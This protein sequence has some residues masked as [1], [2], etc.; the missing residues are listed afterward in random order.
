M[1][2]DSPQDTTFL[3]EICLNVFKK[4]NISQPTC[5]SQLPHL[6]DIYC[7]N[8]L[9]CMYGSYAY[10]TFIKFNISISLSH[11]S[12]LAIGITTQNFGK[13][14]YPNLSIVLQQLRRSYGK[15]DIQFIENENTVRFKAYSYI[16][17]LSRTSECI[18]EKIDSSF[19][20]IFKLFC[21]LF[22]LPLVSYILRPRALTKEKEPQKHSLV[23]TKYITDSTHTDMKSI[24]VSTIEKEGFRKLNV[25]SKEGTTFI[26]FAV[27]LE[28]NIELLRSFP[29][30]F[31]LTSC[32]IQVKIFFTLS[33]K[34]TF[35]F[36][37]DDF[38]E[39]V[40]YC[41]QKNYEL[42]DEKYGFDMKQRCLYYGM[43]ILYPLY[44]K[45]S[46]PTLAKYLLRNS[47]RG[48]SYFAHNLLK[49]L[50]ELKILDCPLED[51]RTFEKDAL[52]LNRK[53]SCCVNIEV[54]MFSHISYTPD[55]YNTEK[56]FIETILSSK[57]NNHFQFT[58]VQF[59]P[60]SCSIAY[61][62]LKGEMSFMQGIRGASNLKYQKELQ[63]VLNLA[64][65]HGIVFRS[66]PFENILISSD[67][68][69]FNITA[70][71]IQ[72]L[73]INENLP[74]DAKEAMKVQYQD[75]MLSYFAGILMSIGVNSGVL[76]WYKPSEFEVA[77]LMNL[78]HEKIPNIF[79]NVLYGM[80]VCIELIDFTSVSIEEIES[81]VN[82]L[83]CLKHP[84]IL[85]VIGLTRYKENLF[86]IYEYYSDNLETLRSISS[87]SLENT[88]HILKVLMPCLS[89]IHAKRQ[90]H[91]QIHIKNVVFC[92]SAVKLRVPLLKDWDS[93]WCSPEELSGMGL[94]AKSDIYQLGNIMYYLLHGHPPYV[95]IEKF[96]MDFNKVLQKEIG[97]N[98]KRAVFDEKVVEE[99]P[100]IVNLIKECWNSNVEERVSLAGLGSEVNSLM[101]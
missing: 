89:L 55:A 68:I 52:V 85:K 28:Q 38:K 3:R 88:V 14:A 13:R 60:E 82:I 61:P 46:W 71:L 75:M 12:C 34:N 57:L 58:Y 87:F 22:T 10:S 80:K 101:I 94:S 84:S 23:L 6:S 25:K 24:L 78:H 99:F 27:N 15:F 40:R 100:Q 92:N 93:V 48:Y 16:P 74:Q 21:Y 91:S 69:L 86:I 29:I 37:P 8:A 76:V 19:G 43:K 77:D 33:N 9:F 5:P 59:F 31:E 26:Y 96:E 44:S 49:H 39:V 20:K 67:T 53:D 54:T 36:S 64:L 98:K 73:E 63:Y 2:L 83:L 81:R 18:F 90:V 17:N 32:Y 65:W 47:M 79:I 30:F 50:V 70:P 11:E 1:E 41:M 66:I 62:V 51:I 42:N 45:S 56:H 4:Y 72:F 95:Q 35:I 97:I 7:C